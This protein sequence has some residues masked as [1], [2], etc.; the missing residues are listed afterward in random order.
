MGVLLWKEKKLELLPSGLAS[1]LLDG[2]EVRILKISPER[3]TVRVAEEIKQS[4]N[5]SSILYI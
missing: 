2:E 4:Y 1:C 3:L 5:K